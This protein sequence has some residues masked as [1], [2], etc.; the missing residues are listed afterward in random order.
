MALR[1]SQRSRPIVPD[2]GPDPGLNPELEPRT[3]LI[4]PA[5]DW[6][7]SLDEKSF[8]LEF[9]GSP[10]RR[11]G[12]QGLR[13]NVAVAMGNSGLCECAAKLE[14]WAAATDEGLRTAAQWALARLRR[15]TIRSH[16]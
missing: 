6:L 14:E 7:A 11:T 8:E 16:P 1:K 4:N 9:N 13:R 10:V 3:E 12:F 15:Q 2:S 5:L